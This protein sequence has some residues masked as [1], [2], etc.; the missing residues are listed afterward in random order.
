MISLSDFPRLALSEEI[1]TM[2]DLALI[3]NRLPDDGSKEFFLAAHSYTLK[4]IVDE[5][6][7]PGEAEKQELTKALCEQIEFDFGKVMTART[8]RSYYGTMFSR[9]VRNS[10][11]VYE[12]ARTTKSMSSAVVSM[13]DMH[14]TEDERLRLAFPAYKR[15]SLLLDNFNAALLHS[16]NSGD[17]VVIALFQRLQ[18]LDEET[19]KYDWVSSQDFEGD[20]FQMAECQFCHKYFSFP[21]SRGIS[22]APQHCDAGE[23][24]KS[25]QALKPSKLS[26]KSLSSWVSIGSKKRCSI[27]TAVR[28]VNEDKTC[29]K[30]SDE[31]LAEQ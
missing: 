23:C 7:L 25:Y 11:N 12:L 6:S 8:G 27:C 5:W 21:L 14:L 26:R 30:C 15:F 31:N 3:F 22:K 29:K 4:D 24:I 28:L 13:E 18:A 1:P 2:Q 20:D 16:V 17:Q 10:R 19:S 9:A